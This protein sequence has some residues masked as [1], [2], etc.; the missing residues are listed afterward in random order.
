MEQMI[1]FNLGKKFTKKEIKEINKKKDN[2]SEVITFQGI[3]KQT[4]GYYTPVKDDFEKEDE[5]VDCR[6]IQLLQQLDNQLSHIDNPMIAD[7]LILTTLRDFEDSQAEQKIKDY[8]L[9]L[10]VK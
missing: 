4:S 9:I 6:F 2:N 10:G 7:L 8:Q 5:Q 1:S 3:D